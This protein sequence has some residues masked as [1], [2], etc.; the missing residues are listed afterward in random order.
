MH[1]NLPPEISTHNRSTT[2]KGKAPEKRRLAA[3]RG[4]RTV[5]W[6]GLHAD[7]CE[8]SLHLIAPILEE[9][10][11]LQLSAE[12][13]DGLVV[14]EAGRVRRDLEVDPVRLAEVDGVEVAGRRRKSPF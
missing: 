1:C 7:V 5:L 3:L 9:G 2:Q 8:L 4:V 13:V 14:E 6:R 10:R 11:Q 12:L